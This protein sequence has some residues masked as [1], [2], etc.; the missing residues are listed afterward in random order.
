MQNPPVNPADMVIAQQLENNSGSMFFAV[1][2]LIIIFSFFVYTVILPK[3]K[4]EE[5]ELKDDSKNEES[6]E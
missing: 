3:F 5:P 4:K 6:G 1:A 2:V